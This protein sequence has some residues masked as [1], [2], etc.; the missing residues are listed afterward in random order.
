GEPARVGGSLVV[1]RARQRSNAHGRAVDRARNGEE[2]AEVVQ[3]GVPQLAEPTPVDQHLATEAAGDPGRPC[4][5]RE[6]RA[7]VAVA[8]R[9]ADDET[10]GGLLPVFAP[11]LG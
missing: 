5:A 1:L 6:V 10:A 3:R 8:I 11:R 2:L 4:K 7:D 9:A